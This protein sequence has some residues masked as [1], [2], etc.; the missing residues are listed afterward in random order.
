MLLNMN[1]TNEKITTSEI[2]SLDISSFSKLTSIEQVNTIS[3]LNKILTTSELVKKFKPTLVP[4]GD[5]F[6]IIFKRKYQA[7]K[8][9]L[10]L[11]AN[12]YIINKVVKD[13]NGVRISVH[14]GTHFSF[15]NILG[16]IEY[17]G[18][19]IRETE[20]LT[21][22]KTLFFKE[23]ILVNKKCLDFNNKQY[24]FKYSSN[25]HKVYLDFQNENQITEVINIW[26]Y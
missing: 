3:I 19:G 24:T 23:S 2:L 9:A 10:Y 25:I 11:K 16:N 21:T 14:E 26:N 6:H 17:M 1:K 5:G 4:N 22:M 8:V 18:N 7:Y 13:F 20:L 15:L 12:E